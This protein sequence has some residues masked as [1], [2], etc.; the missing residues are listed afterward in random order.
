[1][2]EA[3]KKHEDYG[4]THGASFEFISLCS[5]SYVGTNQKQ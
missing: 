4:M 1:M 5:P 2:G 3:E